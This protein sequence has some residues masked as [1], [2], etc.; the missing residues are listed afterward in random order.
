MVN[1]NMVIKVKKYIGILL[2]IVLIISFLLGLYLY[3]LNKINEQIAFEAEYRKLESE[4]IIRTAQNILLEETST[5]ENI[6]T[7]NTKLTEKQYYNEC[8]HLIETQREIDGALINKNESELQIE[9]IGWEIQKFT[10]NEVVVYKEINDFCNEHYL[11]KDVEGEINIYKLD[12]Y[13]RE[14]DLIQNTGIETRYLPEEDLEKLK[15]GIKAY[16]IISVNQMLEDF[17]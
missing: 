13:D 6:I 11:L 2:L 9:Y 1:L 17:E 7:P 15:V 14:V 8:E 16:G 12:K 5:T 3:R 4:N 10:Q